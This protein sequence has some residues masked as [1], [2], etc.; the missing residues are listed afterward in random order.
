MKKEN[1]ELAR[2]RR[3][4]QRKQEENKKRVVKFIFIILPLALIISFTV[5]AVKYNQTH[6]TVATDSTT[7]ALTDTET[8]DITTE[9]VDNVTSNADESGYNTDTSLVVQEGDSLNIDYVGSIDGVE[10]SGGNTN[11]AGTELT[12]GSDSYIDGFE[13]QLIGHNVGETV[14]VTV[15]FPE[16]YGVDDLNGKEAVFTVTINGIYEN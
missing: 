8:A 15:T 16:N 14:D 11:S 12:I 6:V 1:K 3:A 5:F 10:F 13:D 2:E 7:E 4:K 9:S